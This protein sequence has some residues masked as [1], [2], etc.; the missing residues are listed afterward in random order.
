MTLYARFL[1]YGTVTFL[2]DGEVFLEST[3]LKDGSDFEVTEPQA[4]GK[5]NEVFSGW[6]QDEDHEVPVTFPAKVHDDTTYY[7]SLTPKKRLQNDSV[8][9]RM[10]WIENWILHCWRN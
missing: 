6:F 1:E 9:E 7:G 5:E 10:K 2:L 3:F 8:T 4:P